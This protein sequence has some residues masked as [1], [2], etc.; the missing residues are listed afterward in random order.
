MH[1]C[2]DIAS[3]GPKS[4]RAQYENSQRDREDG[5]VMGGGENRMGERGGGGH[6]ENK[7]DPMVEKSSDSEAS[8]Y[9]HIIYKC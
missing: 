3:L 7:V 2:Y 8:D 1:Q 4:R 5:K 9:Y 6:Q